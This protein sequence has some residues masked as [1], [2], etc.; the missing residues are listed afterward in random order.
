MA[1]GATSAPPPAQ[2]AQECALSALCNM[3]RGPDCAL[4]F[5]SCC[6]LNIA[7]TATSA[8]ISSSI[9]RAGTKIHKN[10]RLSVCRV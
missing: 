4:K 7:A 3:K 1:E 9:L 2:L 6:S 5:H 8:E 10:M